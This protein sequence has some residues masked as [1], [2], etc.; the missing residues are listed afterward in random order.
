MN[1]SMVKRFGILKL[2]I[3]Q[4]DESGKSRPKAP[5]R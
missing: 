5:S 3:L 4:M 2:A 1:I